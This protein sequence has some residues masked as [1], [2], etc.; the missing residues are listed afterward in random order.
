VFSLF[1]TS[2]GANTLHQG[3]PV[4]TLSDGQLVEELESAARG[5]GVE[6]DRTAYLMAVKPEPAYVL[7]S[8]TTAFSGT[9][10][11]TY[12]AYVMPIG[13]GSSVRGVSSGSVQGTASTRYQY[14]DVNAGAQLGN[15]IAQ[16]I[17]R[18]RQE[19][20][21]RR[22]LEVLNEYER[23]VSDRRLQTERMIEEFFEENP[24]L[25]NRRTL[26]AAVAPWAASE[27]YA[28][29]RATLD[30]AKEIIHALPRGAGLSGTWYG[31]FAQTTKTVDGDVFAF[32][33]FVRL[34]LSQTGS[35][36][37][38]QGLLGSGEIL[39]LAGEAAGQNLGATVANTTSGINVRLT[40]LVAHN[41]ITGEFS[42]FGAGTRLD[43]TFTLFR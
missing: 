2:C 22:G 10:N 34:D 30:R 37:T 19:A 43:G 8:S 16:A 23:R 42:G 3:V 35:N 38:G 1:L 12:N 29:G 32:S 17:S 33:E 36:L 18:S 39:E 15:A 21:R 41:Q 20:Y 14:T 5:L 31:V 26:V 6:L 4:A 13:Y 9:V 28:D 27:E 24:G 7:T 40:A 11:S 25:Q